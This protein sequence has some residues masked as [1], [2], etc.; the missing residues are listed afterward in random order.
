MKLNDVFYTGVPFTQTSY[1]TV[2]E[3]PQMYQGGDLDLSGSRVVIGLVT[4]RFAI[5]DLLWVLHWNRHSISI[6]FLQSVSIACYAKRCTSYRKSA[7]LSVCPSVT[8]WH[9]VKTTQ[10]TIMGSSL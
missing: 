10:A 4:I 6:G 5:Y 3:K 2:F 1:L 8:R 7:R 9:C